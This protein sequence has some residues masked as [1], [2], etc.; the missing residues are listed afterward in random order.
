MKKI[1]SLLVITT[2]IFSLVASLNIT[3]ASAA[4]ANI[5]NFQYFKDSNSGFYTALNGT[6]YGGKYF[7]ISSQDQV[8]KIT[9]HQNGI[10]GI[11]EEPVLDVISDKYIWNAMTCKGVTN[12][13]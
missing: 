9:F 12:V 6:T 13:L 8:K 4:S 2:M 1:I 3:T 7:Q 11:T 10:E 5:Y